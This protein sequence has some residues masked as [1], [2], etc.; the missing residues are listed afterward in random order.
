M[1]IA[2]LAYPTLGLR[3]DA[4]E[5]IL[6]VEKDP[7][8][9]F[10]MRNAARRKDEIARMHSL[11]LSLLESRSMGKT[12]LDIAMA[13]Y[14]YIEPSDKHLGEVENLIY[15]EMR[16]MF[17]RFD[18]AR[19]WY[20]VQIAFEALK[21]LYFKAFEYVEVVESAPGTRRRITHRVTLFAG[22]TQVEYFAEL[23]RIKNYLT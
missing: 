23:D 7:D 14:Q 18:G 16:T 8:Y 12:P 6:D 13:A 19:P 11:L 3:D 17:V 9:S 1:S 15:T 4:D 10:V 2:Q 20:P 21:K 22:M 5:F